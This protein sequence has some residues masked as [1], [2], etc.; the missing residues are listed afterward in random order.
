M[1]GALTPITR[2][3]IMVGGVV[4]PGAKLY[5]YLSGTSTPHPVYNHTDL[6]PGHAHTNPVIADADGVLPVIF[7]DAVAYR[8]LVTDAN[9]VTIFPAQDD[10]LSLEDVSV[11]T[12]AANLVYAGPVS[13][14]PAIPA[15]RALAEADLPFTAAPPGACDGRL[16]LVTG[17][18][19]PV[20]DVTA[21]TTLYYTPYSGNSIALYTGAAWAIH[22]FTERSLSLAGLAANTLYD[23]WL[24]DNSGTLTLET[25]AWTNGTTRATALTRQDGVLVQ[26]GAT[27]RRYLGTFRT[28]ASV[29]QAEDSLAKRWLWNVANRVARPLRAME[30]ANTWTYNGSYR[31]ANNNAANQIDLIVGVAEDALEVR[32]VASGASDSASNR[33]GVGIGL[34]STTTLAAGTLATNVSTGVAN[35]G[36]AMSAN[37]VTIPTEGRHFFAWLEQAQA[38]GATN[39]WVGDNNEPAVAQSGIY[40]MWRA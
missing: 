4:A 25:T 33:A 28:T 1:A 9:D 22:T 13:G 40:G 34:D 26:S 20:T 29:G 12:Q 16:T 35:G 23:V 8:F 31:Q 2:W 19:V 39:T 24:Y 38:G 37:L 30:P 21:A 36:L 3:Q 18:P 32:V 10:I 6:D 27:T 14:G 7:L 15:F 11:A 5:T 17:V